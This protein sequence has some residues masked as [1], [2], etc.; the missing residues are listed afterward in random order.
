VRAMSHFCHDEIGSK[1]RELRRGEKE[2]ERDRET[3]RTYK[4]LFFLLVREGKDY[5]KEKEMDV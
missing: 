3:K 4:E 5:E 1:W 2:T